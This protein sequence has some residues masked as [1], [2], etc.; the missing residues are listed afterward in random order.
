MAAVDIQDSLSLNMQALNIIAQIIQ[1]Q[2]AMPAEKEQ[3]QTMVPVM[4]QHKVIKARDAQ[5]QTEE[6]HREINHTQNIELPS[7]FSDVAHTIFVITLGL[8]LSFC[9]VKLLQKI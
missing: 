4:V 8:F 1:S 7:V 2:E 5:K 3:N 6:S 9:I